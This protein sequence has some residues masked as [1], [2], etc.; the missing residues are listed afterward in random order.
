MPDLQIFQLRCI[1]HVGNLFD[2][3]GSP[4]LRERKKE[5]T[6]RALHEAAVRLAAERGLDRLTIE[7]IA[8]AAMI[9]RRTFSS[10]FASK[11]EALLYGSQTWMRRLFELVSARPAGEAPWAALSAAV[12]E[13]MAGAVHDPGWSAQMRLLRGHPALLAHQVASY[14]NTERELAAELTRRLPPGADRRAR[15]L[16]AVFLTTLR[17]A[18]QQWLDQP[19]VSLLNVLDEALALVGDRLA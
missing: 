19:E 9:S 8:D 3:S 7:A 18:V 5:A 4:G 15:L 2:M 14:A 12:R 16:A 17:V 1:S 13:M 11:E 6:L 10:Y